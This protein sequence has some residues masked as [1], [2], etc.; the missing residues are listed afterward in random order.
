MVLVILGV[1]SAI[2]IPRFANA[3]QNQRARVAA[4]RLV[5][6]L[7]MVQSR[8][9]MTSTTLTV[10]FSVGTGVYAVDGIADLKSG[11]STYTTD[12]GE[13]PFDAVIRGTDLGGTPRSGGTATLSFDGFGVASVGGTVTIGAGTSAI[14]VVIDAPSGKARIQ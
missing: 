6:D 13:A 4:H 14:T 7:T 1:T 3:N 2:A 5:A 8:A 11:A 12:L 9:N 10:K